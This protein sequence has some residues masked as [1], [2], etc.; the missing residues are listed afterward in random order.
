MSPIIL[1]PNMEAKLG[2]KHQVTAGEVK[3]CFENVC[4][5]YIEETAIQHVT[6]PATHWFLAETNHGRLLKVI[7]VLR[8]GNLYIKSAFNANQT[9]IDLYAKLNQQQ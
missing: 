6:D 2:T 1:S 4:G 9:S 7:F 5:E 3:Q 8:D